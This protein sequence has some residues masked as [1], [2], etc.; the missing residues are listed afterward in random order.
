MWQTWRSCPHSPPHFYCWCGCFSVAKWNSTVIYA[1]TWQPNNWLSLPLLRWLLLYWLPS[2]TFFIRTAMKVE[3]APVHS[4]LFSC[5]TSAKEAKYNIDGYSPK[6]CCISP[7]IYYKLFNFSTWKKRSHL[8][9]V[10][11]QLGQVL[12]FAIAA[13]AFATN[14]WRSFK[15]S[16]RVLPP[17]QLNNKNMLRA[18]SV[19]SIRLMWA[20]D[21]NCHHAIK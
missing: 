8:V 3:T 12:R 15:N 1:L 18:T 9:L 4:T 21:N 7:C 14:K 17:N 13:I 11:L 10:E 6:C 16:E 2:M 20:V 19:T 5:K